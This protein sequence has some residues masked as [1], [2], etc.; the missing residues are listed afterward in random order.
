LK[1]E[2]YW[3][4][5]GKSLNKPEIIWADY[6]QNQTD[7]CVRALTYLTVFNKGKISEDDLRN[8]YNLFLSIHTIN[9]G[10]YSDKSFEAVRKLATKSLLNRNQTEENKYEYVLFNPS[11]ADFVL[12][13]YSN[14]IDLICNILKSLDNE[15]SIDYMHALLRSDKISNSHSSRILEN[16]F[17]Y[18]FERK[19]KDED[20][21]F[22]IALCYL[23][24]FNEKL[25][26]SIEHFLNTLINAD[27]PGG[28][29]LWELLM[30][31]SDFEPEIKFQ[32]FK[33]LYNFIDVAYDEDTLKKLL[34]FVD[35]YNIEDDNIL[36]QIDA[37]LEQYLKSIV[38]SNDFD[39]DYSKHLNYYYHP[40]GY[41][42]YDVDINA[43]ENEI[44][45][46]LDSYLDGFNVNV[47]DRISFNTSSI[48]SNIDIDYRITRYMENYEPD[49]DR[50][51][52]GGY[53]GGRSGE[54]DIDAIFERS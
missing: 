16:L 2:S 17:D 50:D 30:I 25:N 24:F 22:L 47:L 20:W 31:L 45:E 44:S 14:E 27:N 43:I 18:F 26:K 39:I 23:D 49:Y 42:D 37:L 34:D 40:D 46:S 53:Y 35:Q 9:L 51:S 5:I 15:V 3:P 10:D 33:F 1:P 21:D 41:S 29:R 48:I 54:D 6:F 38:D 8:S 28:N 4:Y 19:L 36:M 11:I 7:D 12:S 13:T 52:H 32:N